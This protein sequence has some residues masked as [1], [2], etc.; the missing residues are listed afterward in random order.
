M[1]AKRL[2][3]PSS[4]L[5]GIWLLVILRFQPSPLDSKLLVALRKGEQSVSLSLPVHS[6]STASPV[7]CPLM[8]GGV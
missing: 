2:C 8:A 7:Q 3:D 1:P 4:V 6:L 5:V